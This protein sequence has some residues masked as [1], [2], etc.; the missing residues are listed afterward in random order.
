M[1][2]I[3]LNEDIKVIINTNVKLIENNG[4]LTLFK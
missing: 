3:I 2:V 1:Q 4:Y